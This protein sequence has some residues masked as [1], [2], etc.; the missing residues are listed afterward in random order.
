MAFK[1]T[2]RPLIYCSTSVQLL[3]HSVLEESLALHRESGGYQEIQSDLY[4]VYNF[5]AIFIALS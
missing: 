5:W 3:L 4:I 2:G 1:W